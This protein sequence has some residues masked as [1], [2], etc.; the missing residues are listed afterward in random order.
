M[1]RTYAGLGP[2]G[3]R[4]L[5]MAALAAISSGY[6]QAGVA[7]DAIPVGAAPAEAGGGDGG[8]RQI[9]EIVVT[10]QK[11]SQKLIDVPLSVQVH[12][13][14]TLENAVIQDVAD[15][16]L[17]TPGVTISRVI[18]NTSPYIRGIGTTSPLTGVESAVATYIDGIYQPATIGN[19]FAFNNISS[20][21]ILKGPQGTLYGRN[22]TGGV[23]NIKT[24]DPSFD[25][26]AQIKLGYQNYDTQT[27]TAYLSRGFSDSVAA[28]LAIYNTDQNDGFGENTTLGTEFLTEE[29]FSVRSKVL[30]DVSPDTQI[31]FVGDLTHINS[32][33]GVGAV[34]IR[35]GDDGVYNDVAFTDTVAGFPYGAEV[36]SQGA[37]LQFDHSFESLS[38]KFISAYRDI[39]SYQQF[40][41]LADPEIPSAVEV[42]TNNHQKTYSNELQLTS[43]L[44]GR[45]SW[46]AGIF[47]LEDEAVYDSPD[48]FTVSALTPFGQL[49]VVNIGSTQKLKSI[50]GY[51]DG[52]W[53]WDDRTTLIGGVRYTLDARD[54]V[55]LKNPTD[56]VQVIDGEPVV[57]TVPT[58]VV[59]TGSSN[60]SKVTYRAVVERKLRDELMVYLSYATGFKSGGF[61]GN[62]PENPAL[63]PENV[64]ATE[65][66]TKMELF[67]RRLR[68]SAAAFHYDYEDLQVTRIE[69]VAPISENAAKA[70]IDGVEIEGA[71]NVL[72]GLDLSFGGQYLDARYT[73]YTS[74]PA[75][76]PVEG[77]I[78]NASAPP[79][80]ASGNQLR[81]SPKYTANFGISYAF[82]VGNDEIRINGNYLYN[83]GYYFYADE[84][85]RQGSFDVINA[86]VGWY[87]DDGRYSVSLIGKNLADSEYFVACRCGDTAGDQA[88]YAEPRRYGIEVEGRF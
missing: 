42:R 32:D 10:A 20:I 11:R 7:D 43:N 63:R 68:L 2:A 77:G 56:E 45:L 55:G 1:N 76:V 64:K 12:S 31:R 79:I 28:D 37:S 38:L 39:D 59:Q 81:L 51:V 67:D 46:I 85:V 27:V 8:E 86:K 13:A 71:L 61:A 62:A 24:R 19:I 53:A 35:D 87:F 84:R 74:V 57:V 14:E 21:E 48:G 66:G 54:F 26:T 23:I 75:F 40:S 78:S 18:A 33:K 69:G 50:S 88:S 6:V 3:R 47:H 22:A 82:S 41:Q 44:N 52:S 4:A 80:D 58:A 15:L 73:D 17:I 72:P 5:V 25:P 65:L 36:D 9:E 16:S 60:D 34:P 30:V 49:K 70:K 83:D 29:E